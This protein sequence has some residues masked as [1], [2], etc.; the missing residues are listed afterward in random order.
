MMQWNIELDGVER[1]I[2]ASK[3]E[4]AVAENWQDSAPSSIWA[5]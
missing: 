3:Q 4:A 1:K 2:E 5:F